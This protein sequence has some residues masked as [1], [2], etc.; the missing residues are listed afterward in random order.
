MSTTESFEQEPKTI[1]NL[2][3]NI[4]DSYFNTI[5]KNLSIHQLDSFNMFLSD[6]LTKTIKQ[7]NPIQNQWY[8]KKNTDNTLILAS[9]E[10][11]SDIVLTS[12]IYFGA[13]WKDNKIIN[14]VSNIYISKPLINENILKKN[15]YKN[16]ENNN[17]INLENITRQLYPN[18]A[19]L[20]NKT[21]GSNL[22]SNIIIKL[23]IKIKQQGIG[24]INEILLKDNWEEN[25]QVHDEFLTFVKIKKDIFKKINLGF[26]P[27]ML[28]SNA[29]ILKNQ[30]SINLKDMGECPYDQGGYF[31]IDGKE[32]VLVGQETQVNN[33]LYIQKIKNDLNFLYSLEIRSI[34]ENTFE[35]PRKTYLYLMDKKIDYN[36]YDVKDIKIKK[37]IEKGTI[38]VKLEGF[39]EN[40]PLFI[41]FRALGFVSDKEILQLIL[42]DLEDDE[43]IK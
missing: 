29:C 17:E 14:N 40:I 32:K 39:N 27:I 30:N 22:Y 11:K 24:G 38:R 31:I 25:V 1:N 42:Y 19:R 21:Y 3:W 10:I 4:I 18:E 6:K 16:N 9:D 13:E 8:L 35:T 41:L 43:N 15:K 23:T 12:E 20:K 36:N 28:G 37:I 5:D 2:L 33:K 34:R 26:I 7:F